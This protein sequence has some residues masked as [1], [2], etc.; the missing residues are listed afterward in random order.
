MPTH[1]YTSKDYSA[2]HRRREAY[3]KRLIEKG[4]TDGSMKM[5]KLIMGKFK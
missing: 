5:D 2:L 1:G 3:R 4:V